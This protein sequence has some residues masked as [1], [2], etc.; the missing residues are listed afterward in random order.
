MTKSQKKIMDLD[1]IF[2]RINNNENNKKNVQILAQKT[3][4]IQ[5]ISHSG[6]QYE[7]KN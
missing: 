2:N 4:H 6:T 7:T 5:K 3:C 1:A